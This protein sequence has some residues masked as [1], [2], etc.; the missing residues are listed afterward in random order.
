[1]KRILRVL[2]GTLFVLALIALAFLLLS[3]FWPSLRPAVSQQRASPLALIFAGWSF[4]CLQLGAGGRGKE[5]LKGILLG[6]AFVLWGGEQFLPAG[7]GA[8]IVDSVVVAIFVVDL[9][10]VIKG[11]LGRP[12]GS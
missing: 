4:I 1:L 8:A 9:G 11:S 5:A 2:S 12:G 7:P 3:D 6:L 10:L